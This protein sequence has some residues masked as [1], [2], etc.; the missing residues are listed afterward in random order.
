MSEMG[1]GTEFPYG[2]NINRPMNHLGPA[3]YCNS[4][5]QCECVHDAEEDCLDEKKC[6]ADADCKG[7]MG[8]QGSCHTEHGYCVCMEN[9]RLLPN[10][11]CGI[12]TKSM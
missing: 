12:D 2:R 10:G 9:F 11:K 1:H 4:K 6:D 7:T 8:S 5:S 3:E